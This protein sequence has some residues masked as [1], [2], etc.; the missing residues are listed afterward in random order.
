LTTG[1]QPTPSLPLRAALVAAAGIVGAGAGGF[2]GL[3]AAES[4]EP[5]VGGAMVAM[6]AILGGALG[7]LGG[8]LAAWKLPRRAARVGTSALGIPAALLLAFIALRLWQMDQQTRDPEEA[9]TGL[10][11]FVASIERD[12]GFDPVLATRVE[13]NAF[14][15]H[16]YLTLPDGRNCTGRLRAG[17]QRRVGTA[18]PDSAAPEA[19]RDA[20]PEGAYER[21]SWRI[22]GGSSGAARIDQACR[23]TAPQLQ[24]LAAV[25]AMAP[26]LADSAPSCD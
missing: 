12:P 5:L 2:L 9:Y 21:L 18:L 7:L 26:N 22:E 23:S 10:P 6:G 15:R 14:T 16:W 20:P 4:A 19:C 1:R 24:R 17:V 25:L 11:V 8:I 3:L 13:V